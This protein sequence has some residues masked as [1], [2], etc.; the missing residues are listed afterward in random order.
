MGH[1][2]FVFLLV[3]TILFGVTLPSL[4]KQARREEDPS[5]FRFL[6]LALFLKLI[7]GTLLRYYVTFSVYTSSDATGYIGQGI[8][9]A[10]QLVTGTYHFSFGALRGSDSISFLTGVLFTIL[11]PAKLTGFMVFSW[12]GFWGMFLFYRAFVIAVPEG[13]ARTYARYLFLFPTMWFWPSSIGKEA[14]LVFTLGIA[15]FGAARALNGRVLRGIAISLLGL[16]LMLFVRPHIAGMFAVAFLAGFVL[17]RST[18]ERVQYALVGKLVGVVIVAVLAVVMVN[19]AARFLRVT[20]VSAS[21]AVTELQNVSTRSDTGG[22]AFQ[23]VVVR[24]PL[25]VPKAFI[26][27]LFRPFPTE[28]DNTQAMAAA[29][30]STFLLFLTLKRLPWVKAAL[31]SMRRQAYVGLA[32]AYTTI[33][34]V[35]FA[36]FPNFG[37]LARERD[38]LFPF[39]VVLLSIPSHRRGPDETEVESDGVLATRGS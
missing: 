15:A 8:D 14:W 36:S 26:T 23:P 13:R 12:L 7:V 34:V 25:Q 29:L 35:A 10:K 20:D 32:L 9:I 19:S 38:Q 28:A 17:R 30:E 1:E 27:V 6:V 22:S 31:L 11:G 37:L 39:F 3:A 21:G 18:G 24:S 2:T 33:F 5:L 16:W 4:A